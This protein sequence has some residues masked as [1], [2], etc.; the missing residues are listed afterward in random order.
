[1][2]MRYQNQNEK[3]KKKKEKKVDKNNFTL[4]PML[5]N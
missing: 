3:K 5:D 1:M 4:S 2:Y